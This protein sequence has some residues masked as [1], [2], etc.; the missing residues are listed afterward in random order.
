MSNVHRPGPLKQQNKTHKHGK[1][2]SKGELDKATKG[3]VDIKNLSKRARK[4]ASKLERRNLSL[5]ARKAKRDEILWSKREVGSATSAP[6]LIAV[7]SVAEDVDILAVSEALEGCDPEAAVT[8]NALGSKHVAVPRF[9]TRYHLITP[10]PGDLNALLDAAKAA[11]TILFAYSLENGVDTY[12]EYIFSVLFGHGIPTA[13]HTAMGIKDLPTKKQSEAKKILQR[14]VEK[15]F[16]TGKIIGLDTA[17]DGL[18]LL[19]QANEQRRKVPA[20]RLHRSYLLAENVAFQDGEQG[21]NN[22]DEGTLLLTGYVRSNKLRVNGLVHLPGW[23]DFQ[24]SQIDAPSDPHPLP[25]NSKNFVN[26]DPDLVVFYA[27]PDPDLQETLQS[28]ALLDPLEGEQT[29][30]TEEEMEMAAEERRQ[31]AMDADKGV[32]IVK[33]VPKGTS[34]YQAAW[35]LDVDVRKNNGHEEGDEEDDEEDDAM[36]EDD[37]FF[38]EVRD[39]A[40]GTV[41]DDDDAGSGVPSQLMDDDEELEEISI[42]TDK[43][44]KYDVEGMDADEDRQQ[45]EKLRAE[46]KAQEMFPDEIDTPMDQ[47]ARARFAK[48]RGLKSFRT[49]EWDPKENL[50]IDYARIFQFENFGRTKKRVLANEEDDDEDEEE[51]RRRRGPRPGL[52]VTIHVAN[53]PKRFVHSLDAGAPLVVYQPLPLEQKMSLINV[54]LRTVKDAPV[55]KSKERLVFH[56]GFRRFAVQPVFSQHTN[57]TRHKYCRF[58]EKDGVTVASFYAPITFSPA[59]AMAFKEMKDGSAELVAT[60]AMLSV[61]PDRIV[62]KR[63]ILSGHPY[64][65]YTK[66]AI[67]RYMFFNREDITWFK[68]VELRTKWGRRGHIKDPIGT[69]G[70]MRCFFDG[71]LKS[72]DTVLMNLYKR[73]FPKWTYQK[74]VRTP[75]PLID[76]KPSKKRTVQVKEMEMD[77]G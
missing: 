32:K 35:I 36:S 14:H 54:V 3:K 65:I 4:Q 73:V 45:L 63:I 23:G 69:H 38:P 22:N 68:P 42:G 46:R 13:I 29:W 72:Q 41:S 34:D 67:V 7:V 62:A 47:Q 28:E 19:R 15:R 40:S 51:V 1:H 12:G 10:K 53:V 9:K 21:E 75:A 8:V 52:Y 16:P 44:A 31:A 27:K 58:L 18:Q 26:S 56:L 64:R 6:H 55:V 25:N 33:K 57:G 37:G 43:D 30:P 48:Y 24:I 76:Y 11:D 5:A 49:S 60:G 74:R 17:Q 39:P 50:P 70:H 20:L 66:S 77:Q 71:K 59:S 2:K 61:N